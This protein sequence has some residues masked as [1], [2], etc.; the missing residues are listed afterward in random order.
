MRLSPHTAFH[1]KKDFCVLTKTYTLRNKFILLI[2]FRKYLVNDGYNA[3]IISMEPESVLYRF[4]YIPD[5]HISLTNQIVR[6]IIE[7]EIFYRQSDLILW[8]VTKGQKTNIYNL[9]PDYDVKILFNDAEILVYIEISLFYKQNY[10]DLSEA[11]IRDIYDM[12]VNSLTNYNNH[13]NGI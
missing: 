12:L 5:I 13:V 11:C 7:G 2:K 6:D 3:Y 4:E 10:D 1:H 8:N 9:Y